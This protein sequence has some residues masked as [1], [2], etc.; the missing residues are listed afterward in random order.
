M[1]GIPRFQIPCNGYITSLCFPP[2]RRIEDRIRELCATAVTAAEGELEPA[3]RELSLLLGATIEHMRNSA[4]RLLIAGTPLSEPRRRSGDNN[5]KPAGFP[6]RTQQH[7]T[8]EISANR[9]A[10]EEATERGQDLHEQ[11]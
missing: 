10:N 8:A 2:R 6:V 4:A 5:V 3:L 9:Q 7:S 1:F 11:R